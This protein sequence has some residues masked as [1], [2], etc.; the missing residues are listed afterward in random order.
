[1]P[2]HAKPRRGYVLRL[3]GVQDA[4]SGWS[5]AREVRELLMS[6]TYYLRCRECRNTGETE[7][8]DGESLPATCGECG[9]GDIEVSETPFPEKTDGN[10]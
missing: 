4:V 9:S 2:D 6:R 1:M 8:E 3:L 10:G 7:A 5:R